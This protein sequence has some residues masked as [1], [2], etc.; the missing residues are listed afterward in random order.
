MIFCVTMTGISTLTNCGCCGQNVSYT[1]T[2]F[3]GVITVWAGTA[4][5]C[6][7]NEIPLRHNQAEGDMG[8]CNNG[9]II[10]YGIQFV[11]NYYTSRLDVTLSPELDG[12]TV[13]CSVNDGNN[14]MSVG[15]RTLMITTGKSGQYLFTGLD[16]WTGLLDWT[17]LDSRLTSK[18]LD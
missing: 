13:T 10:G 3:G 14:V 5:M 4:F 9:A 12:R 15:T 6:G 7:G 16:H 1:C 2:V 17:I 8:E 18:F 11:S